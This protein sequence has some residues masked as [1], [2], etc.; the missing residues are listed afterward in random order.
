MGLD[1]IFGRRAHAPTR[2]E[3]TEQAHTSESHEDLSAEIEEA[4]V[5]LK[6]KMEAFI[7][8]LRN[9]APGE[10]LSD[11][12]KI[13][14]IEQQHAAVEKALSAT[15]I[16]GA[17][18][19]FTTMLAGLS[20]ASIDGLAQKLEQF[21]LPSFEQMVAPY[22]GTAFDG[23]FMRATL[24]ESAVMLVALAALSLNPTVAWKRIAAVEA[25]T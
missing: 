15:A 18:A 3:G 13:A 9:R 12:E 19:A 7:D 17:T 5:S 1:G 4:E 11:S 16:T 23:I 2:T 6:S 25:N 24:A 22:A 21:G 20:Y 8:K 14:G 10:E